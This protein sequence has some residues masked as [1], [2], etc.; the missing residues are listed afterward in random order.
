M[1]NI[2]CEICGCE[3]KTIMKTEQRFRDYEPEDVPVYCPD[4]SENVHLLLHRYVCD[5][6]YKNLSHKIK[7]KIIN[8]SDE[9]LNN[10]NHKIEVLKKEYIEKLN[11][12]DNDA[13]IL[14]KNI[15]ILKNT[16]HLKDLDENVIKY[17]NGSCPL[18]LYTDMQYVEEAIKNE[19]ANLNK[20]TLR[21]W[22]TFYRVE[23]SD[24]SISSKSY[25]NKEEFIEILLSSKVNNKTV[26]EIFDIM[27]N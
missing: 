7:H 1:N 13:E 21:D 11:K 6:C 8:K 20:R 3:F 26:K 14:M 4:P 24:V 10:I 25:I 5:D 17:F 19:N 22:E 12:I 9:Y 27:N 2:T 16:T 15:N 18:S 23:L